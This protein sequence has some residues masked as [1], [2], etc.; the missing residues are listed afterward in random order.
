MQNTNMTSPV[1]A[2]NTSHC[3]IDT[4]QDDDSFTEVNPVNLAAYANR[5]HRSNIDILHYPSDTASYSGYVQNNES[6]TKFNCPIDLAVSVPRD[7][8]QGRNLL[9]SN[10]P[11]N[12]AAYARKQPDY[13]APS[14]LSANDMANVSVRGSGDGNQHS[15]S[16]PHG[17]AQTVSTDIK[18]QGTS[19]ASVQPPAYQ[20][21]PP[22]L[23][24]TL[25][26]VSEQTRTYQH[27]LGLT[28]NVPS[29]SY[30]SA[31]WSPVLSPRTAQLV[32][33]AVST[34][35]P[36]LSTDNTAKE[37]E[38]NPLLLQLQV[39]SELSLWCIFS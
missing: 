21:T 8:S 20:D 25:A 23:I 4:S 24:R 26:A 12:L 34:S 9:N 37:G 7:Y 11:V 31:H 33:S 22:A 2:S 36:A 6:P 5:M 28:H 3:T 29:S 27:T 18:D 13:N 1:P 32:A 15:V 10:D 16:L 38:H 35:A 30:Q 19:P 39:C 17:A 14:N